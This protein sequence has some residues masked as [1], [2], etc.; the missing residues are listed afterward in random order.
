ML[1]FVM[2]AVGAASYFHLSSDTRALRNGL[3]KSS[4]VEWRE[5]I[6]LN[7]GSLTLGIVRAGLSCVHLDAEARAALRAV[8]G[9]EVAIYQ[10]SAEAKPPDRAAMLAAADAAMTVRGWERLVAVMDGADLVT[11]YM[12]VKTNSVQRMKCCAMV[13]DGRQM[14]VASARANLAPLLQCVLHQSAAQT[15][16]RLLSKR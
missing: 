6:A 15:K 14:I 12:P 3:I 2:L 16:R 13:F 10:L 1:F 5:Q 4:G 8:R 7:V 9:V 11:V